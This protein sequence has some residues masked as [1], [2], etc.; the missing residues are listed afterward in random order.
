[1][2]QA[3]FKRQASVPRTV[4]DCVIGFVGGFKDRQPPGRLGVESQSSQSEDLQIAVGDAAGEP[5][6]KS[7]AVD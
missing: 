6:V 7:Q 2:S 4:I 5:T 1:M 3:A